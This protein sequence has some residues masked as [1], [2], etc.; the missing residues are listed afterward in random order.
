LTAAATNATK[1]VVTGTDGSSY[2]LGATGGTQSVSPTSTTTY[3]ATATGTDGNDVTATASVTIQAS[4][5]SVQHVILL[6]QE[7]HTFDQYFGMLN[8]Y[9]I[10]NHWNVGDDNRTYAVDGIEDKLSLISNQSDDGTPHALFKLKSTC[11]E[12]MTSS[13]LESYGDASRYDFS[14]SRSIVMDGFVH[15]A[16]NYAINCNANGKGCAGTFSDFTGRRA[17]G[18]YDQGFLNYY[19]YMASQFALSDRWFSPI[20]SKSIPNRIATF[21]GGT[22]EGLVLDPGND[23]MLPQLQIPTIFSKLSNANVSWKLYYTVTQ[24]ACLDTD[25]C[26]AGGPG[27]VY[28]A[29]NFSQLTDSYKYIHSNPGGGTCAPPTQPSSVVGDKSNSF[30]IDPTHIAPLSTYYTDLA[31]GTLPS[32]AFIEAGYGVNDE[33]PG[34]G[35]SVLMGQQQV[36][37]LSNALMGSSSWMN[38]VL[39]V[40]YDEGGGPYD[41]V[42]PIAGHSNDFTDATV[43][44]TSVSSIPDIATVSINPDAF[45]PCPAPGG[46][47][48]LNCDLRPGQPGYD[49]N[50]APHIQGFAAQL[51]FRIPNMVISPFVRKHYVSHVPMDHTAILKFVENRFIG[52]SAHLTARDAAQPDLLDF[53]DFTTTPWATPPTP[54]TPVSSSSLGYDPCLPTNFGPL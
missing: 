26:S 37:N 50:D 4:L 19:Y 41:H 52:P 9:R 46:V 35:Q 2:T 48:T 3:T 44:D 33:H 22:T 23:D 32:F 29:T 6:L 47:P 16:Q 1:V 45:R 17:M 43:G 15:T 28:P 18:Y 36:A 34:S 7:N 24:G 27:A 21:T 10:A 30:C 8:P 13:W 49:T 25:D 20:S 53:F 31:N 51:G 39:F 38:S 54:P 14:L 11:V 5:Q 12:D 40:A 42:P